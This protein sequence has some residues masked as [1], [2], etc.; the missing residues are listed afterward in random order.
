MIFIVNYRRNAAFQVN[1]CLTM[2][3]GDNYLLGQ[4]YISVDLKQEKPD[5]SKSEF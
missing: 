4:E 1:A 3:A 2:Q 5:I